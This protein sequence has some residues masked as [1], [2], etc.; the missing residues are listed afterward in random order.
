MVLVGAAAILLWRR[1][2]PAEY[3]LY[4]AIFWAAAIAVKIAMDLTITVPF[5]RLLP[6]ALSG[7]L[8]LGAYAGLRTGILESGI[9]YAAG[10][11]TRLPL[12][13]DRSVAIGI[14][15]GAVEAIV[16]GLSSLLNVLAYLT[17][18]G[19]L[20]SL[21]AAVQVQLTLPFLPI[22]VIE[23]LFTLFCH[24]FATALALYAVRAGLKWL[25]LSIAFKTII[26]GALPLFSHFLAPMGLI[27]YLLVEAYVA[28]LG[29]VSI[30]GLIWLK[31][32]WTGHAH[33]A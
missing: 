33:Q 10:K 19:L 16:L 9:P 11:L 21:P 27:D 24:V 1:R 31:K 28:L 12:D 14:G 25:A 29:V 20:D 18:P 32:R 6:P 30:A 3:F 17:V 26:D 8:I 7:A 23:R 22:P 15:F 2:A 4:G 5:S 13:F